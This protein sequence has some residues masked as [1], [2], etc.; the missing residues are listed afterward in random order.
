MISCP[1]CQHKEIVGAIFCSDCGAPLVSFEYEFPSAASEPGAEKVSESTRTPPPFPVAPLGSVLSLHIIDTGEI[2][3]LT[4]SEEI[5]LGR[6]SQDQPIIPDVDLSPYKAYESGVSRLHA[7][8]KVYEDA[9]MVVDLGSANGTRLNGKKLL[10][11]I[12]QLL[13]HGDVITLGKFKI[14]VLIR[15]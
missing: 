4:L 1:H 6:S 13:A 8:L 12:P 5:T 2:L 14:Q 10:P 7:S 9:V 11:N 3:P 15:S